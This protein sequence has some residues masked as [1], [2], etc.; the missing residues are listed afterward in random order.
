V[1]KHRYDE[2]DDK[3][4]TLGT[5]MLGLTIGCARCHDHKYD[6]IPQRDYYRMLSTFTTTVRSEVEVKPLPDDY[7]QTKAFFDK[8]H[9]PLVEELTR[10]EK[11]QLPA[12]LAAWEKEQAGKAKLPSAVA[13]LLKIPAGE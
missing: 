10:F 6:P 2:M 9:R 12:R 7:V 13:A 8:E 4:A 5:A 1:E 11:T 3:L